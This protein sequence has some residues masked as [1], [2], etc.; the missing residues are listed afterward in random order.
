MASRPAA[1]EVSRRRTE[2]GSRDAPARSSTRVLAST[3]SPL[4]RF[5]P[6]PTGLPKR[7]RVSP[8]AQSTCRSSG[9]RLDQKPIWVRSTMGL[10]KTLVRRA[11]P[12]PCARAAPIIW[13]R[14][15]R[16]PGSTKAPG[17]NLTSERW[18]INPRPPSEAT[19]STPT[20]RP[21]FHPRR[22]T[23]S[24]RSTA[25]LSLAAARCPARL[26]RP[27]S[28]TPRRSAAVHPDAPLCAEGAFD[29]S[30]RSAA[31]LGAPGASQNS[32]GCKHQSSSH[33]ADGRAPGIGQ[34]GQSE[35]RR[36]ENRGVTCRSTSVS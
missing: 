14:R 20:S 36:S 3:P 33:R 30:E 12:G 27:A 10:T 8:T 6:T 28:L 35:R 25:P 15:R 13:K 26:A 1:G 18:S 19:T 7:G 23:M 29:A 34:I 2:P 9:E 5:R 4:T 32:G 24:R 31:E 22:A 17:G 16:H 11:N 21:R